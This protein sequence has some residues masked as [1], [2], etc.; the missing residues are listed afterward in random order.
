MRLPLVALSA[1]SLFAS[2]T[3]TPARNGGWTKTY[4]SGLQNLR[5]GK[6]E[7]ALDD[8]KKTDKQDGG[9]CLACQ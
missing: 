2:R 6:E 8:F 4:K 7:W 1:V 3:C 9:H 5:E